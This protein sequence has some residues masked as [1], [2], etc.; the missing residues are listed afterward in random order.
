MAPPPWVAG[1]LAAVLLLI[2]GYCATRLV[3]A[4]WW[5]RSTD[6]GVDVM[7]TVMG[8]AMAGMLVPRLSLL[9]AR[10][11]AVLFAAGV[12]W[13][14]WQARQ[15]RR[16]HRAARRTG[17]AASAPPEPPA[18]AGHHGAHVLSCAAMVCMLLAA[19]DLSAPVTAG[20]GAL[21]VVALLLAVAVAGSVV[22]S[23]DRIP[24][25]R[26]APVLVPGGLVPPAQ[27]GGAGAAPATG[28]AVRDGAVRDG[29]TRAVAPEHA[30]RARPGPRPVLCPRLAASCQIMMGVAMAYMLILM[31]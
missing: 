13:F 19:P 5:Q 22:V 6:H 11:W 24:A 20:R 28:G 23:T 9:Q 16:R 4:R 27:A 2:A 18:P 12:A 29:A 10:A 3:T 21:P 15:D 14:G 26:P 7:H 31:L 17:P 30:A 1:G 25:L 8:V